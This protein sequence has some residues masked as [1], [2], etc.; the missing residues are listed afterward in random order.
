MKP[1]DW[2]LEAWDDWPVGP[3]RDRDEAMGLVDSY[4]LQ[5][6]LDTV[7]LLVIGAEWEELWNFREQVAGELDN[8]AAVAMVRAEI[9][10]QCEEAL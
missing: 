1:Y 4:L 10:V 8:E 5:N 3:M 9:M 6:A 2:E 7:E